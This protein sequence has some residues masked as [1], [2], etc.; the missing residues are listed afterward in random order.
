MRLIPRLSLCLINALAVQSINFFSNRQSNQQPSLT[1]SS[2]G[3]STL[4]DII[5]ERYLAAT[6]SIKKEHG[7]FK[8]KDK[9]K[10]DVIFRHAILTSLP[11]CSKKTAIAMESTELV[12]ANNRKKSLLVKNHHIMHW[13]SEVGQHWLI[14]LSKV[15]KTITVAFRGTFGVYDSVFYNADSRAVPLDQNLFPNA[16]SDARI[17]AGVQATA[18]KHIPKAVEAL[19]RLRLGY[20]D[21]SIISVGHSLG[22]A[23]ARLFS[24]HLALKEPSLKPSMTYTFAEPITTTLAFSSWVL[25][26]L[27]RNNYLRIISSDDVVPH[28]RGTDPNFAHA[29]K[30]R[31]MHFPDPDKPIYNVCEYDG[32]ENFYNHN[33][34]G[35]LILATSMCDLATSNTPVKD[36]MMAFGRLFQ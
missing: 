36:K 10:L 18:L 15:H 23:V 25:D 19:K 6:N 17:Y 28:L 21:Y 20:K 5:R 2:T 22:A 33:R 32:D 29:R 11:Y 16:Q 26:M 13:T 9:F 34:F 7:V 35:G 27:D 30:A 3:S 24:L 8:S 4:V 1:R 31:V 14:T 12:D